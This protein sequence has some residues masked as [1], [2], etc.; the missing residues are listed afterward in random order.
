MD[1]TNLVKKKKLVVGSVIGVLVVAL[2]IVYFLFRFFGLENGFLIFDKEARNVVKTYRA[3][4]A[5]RVAETER[6]PLLGRVGLTLHKQGDVKN[7]FY[8]YDFEQE[9]LRE[10]F[11][12]EGNLIVG[13]DSAKNKDF[14]A[15]LNVNAKTGGA[16]NFQL[17]VL[18]PKTGLK[19]ITKSDTLRKREAKWAPSG[20]EI[21]FIAQDNVDSNGFIPDDWSIYTTD[22]DGNETFITEGTHPLYSPDGKKLIVLKN[23]GLYLFD[24]ESKGGEKIWNVAG[25]MAFANMQFDISWENN[26]LAWSA[27]DKGEVVLFKINSW[28]PFSAQIIKKLDIHAFWPV[29]SL[30]GNYLVMEEVDWPENSEGEPINPRL[31]IYDMETFERDKDFYVDLSEYMQTS[32]W[33]NDWIY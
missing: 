12:R 32:M 10:V 11:S 9:E 33:V 27:P 25:D 2:L 21:V 3:E 26:L 24:I 8:F 23:D 15:S 31:V 1:F 19:Q 4:V 5:T 13:G 18:N 22:L 16:G 6:N 29:F 20:N 14:V 30:E 28:E 17:W 7:G